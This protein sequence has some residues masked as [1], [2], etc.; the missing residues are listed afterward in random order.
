MKFVDE[1]EAIILVGNEKLKAR[2]LRKLTKENQDEALYL[3]I[4][5]C[6]RNQD[7]CIRCG[8]ENAEVIEEAMN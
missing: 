8:A 3:P 7:N 6:F 4:F 2:Q 1:Y 5:S